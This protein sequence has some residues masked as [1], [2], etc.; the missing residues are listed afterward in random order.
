MIWTNSKGDLREM[1]PR[2]PV[3]VV[4]KTKNKFL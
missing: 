2:G 3:L 4:Q 1:I